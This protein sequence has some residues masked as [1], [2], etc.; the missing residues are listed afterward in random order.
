MASADRSARVCC[1]LSCLLSFLDSLRFPIHY[2]SVQV[3]A[4]SCGL[5]LRALRLS[6][7]PAHTT[8]CRSLP[9]LRGGAPIVCW[10]NGKCIRSG[11]GLWRAR[12]RR[13]NCAW[14]KARSLY[15]FLAAAG[16]L[17]QEVLMLDDV[18]RD[19][20]DGTAAGGIDWTS[21]PAP[22]V[23]RLLGS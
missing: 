19:G 7:C 23:P 16:A 10:R 12:G 2:V 3:H 22:R 13:R 11:R 8:Q 15:F 9:R 14:L 1:L 17:L 20:V 5:A 4:S 21:T 18:D 6:H